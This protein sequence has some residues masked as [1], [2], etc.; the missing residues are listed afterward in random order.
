MNILAALRYDSPRSEMGD[1]LMIEKTLWGLMS[2][3]REVR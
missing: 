1:E 3:P 2:N